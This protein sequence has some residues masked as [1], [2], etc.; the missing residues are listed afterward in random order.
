MEHAK[1]LG[2]LKTPDKATCISNLMKAG[3]G[4]IPV[5]CVITGEI[6]E[7]KKSVCMKY[8]ISEYQLE[9]SLCKH[10]SINGNIFEI[11]KEDK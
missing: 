9:K 2:L 4:P 3:L 1:K 7:S 6:F 11:V 10:V 5:R 8:N